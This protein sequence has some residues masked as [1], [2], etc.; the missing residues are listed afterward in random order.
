MDY[1]ERKRAGVDA[2][3]KIKLL[4][5]LWADDTLLTQVTLWSESVNN[6]ETQLKTCAPADWNGKLLSSMNVV[7][8]IHP[9]GSS[10]ITLRLKTAA[11]TQSASPFLQRANFAMPA[12]DVYI[13][14]SMTLNRH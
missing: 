12:T 14:N 9:Q 10:G 11:V 2:L 6:F 3:T 5:L 7:E 13:S 4:R 1:Q 8:T